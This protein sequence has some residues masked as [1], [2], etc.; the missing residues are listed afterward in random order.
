MISRVMKAVEEREGVEWIG[1]GVDLRKFAKRPSRGS[2]SLH[3]ALFF[4]E[5][6]K[7]RI[8]IQH[9]RLELTDG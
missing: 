2:N 8:D 1:D 9:P 3:S 4:D 5:L 6:Y 7:A